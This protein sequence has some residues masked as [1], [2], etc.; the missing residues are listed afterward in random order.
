M[1]WILF[2][3]NFFVSAGESEDTIKRSKEFVARMEKL[4]I[5]I[6]KK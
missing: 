2:D 5:E 4:I 6:S 3:C 1:V